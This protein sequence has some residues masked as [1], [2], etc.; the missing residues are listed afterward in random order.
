[1]D[2]ICNYM[3]I[4]QSRSVFFLIAILLSSCHQDPKISAANSARDTIFSRFL[5]MV[6]TLPYYD[7]SNLNFR[8][9]KA[10][11]ENDTS[12]LK[13]L[14]VYIHDARITPWMH[15][16]LKPCAVN[17][18]FDTLTADEAYKFSYE[19]AF[20]Q[21][22]TIAN[23]ARR[24]NII[25][26]SAIVY[27]NASKLDSLPCR[28]FQQYE[29]EIDS[30]S[31]AKFRNEILVG[32]FWGL[33]EDNEYRGTDGNSLDVQGYK[34]DFKGNLSVQPRKCYVSRWSSSMDNLA[35]PFMMLLRFCKNLR[36]LFKT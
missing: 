9:L 21:Y 6:D 32:D 27:I 34:K 15:K 29:T 19:S 3:S 12:S 2:V 33:K 23:I 30:A 17:V 16:Y 13:E 26:A 25:K 7:T 5:R 8:F 31:W 11:K 4:L 20:C 1:M 22:Y 24:G 10:Y 18:E 36:R 14:S 35:R 28:V